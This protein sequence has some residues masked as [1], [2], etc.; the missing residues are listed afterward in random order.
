M[1]CRFCCLKLENKE[2]QNE[3]L[4]RITQAM[5]ELFPKEKEK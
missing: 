3:R 4:K 2:T 5:E 1:L